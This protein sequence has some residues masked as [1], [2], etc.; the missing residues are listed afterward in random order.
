[1]T[2]FEA[3]LRP[4]KEKR[5]W[6]KSQNFWKMLLWCYRNQEMNFFF[7]ASLLKLLKMV[8]WFD[9]PNSRR[10]GK[11]HVNPMGRGRGLV[12]FRSGKT[13]L[14]FS[15][16]FLKNEEKRICTNFF[17]IKYD[18]K[19]NFFFSN[20]QNPSAASWRK[21]ASNGKNTSISGS[22]RTLRRFH[23]RQN[24]SKSLKNGWKWLIWS[25]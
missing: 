3:L 11:S 5:I 23:G 25:R 24:Q 22:K 9:F 6:G 8:Y 17:L 20:F 13:G 1:M 7:A 4:N 16:F 15:N 18:T 14:F 2:S 21:M 12:N 10:W 19:E